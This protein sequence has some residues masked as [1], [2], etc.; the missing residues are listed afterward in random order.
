MLVSA[1][2]E[3]T[4]PNTGEILPN[5]SKDTTPHVIRM[6]QGLFTLLPR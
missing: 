6:I 2:V 1:L 4:D 5:E 3:S